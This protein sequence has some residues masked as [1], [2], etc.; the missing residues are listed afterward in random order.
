M[1]D[2]IRRA[3][4]LA[5]WVVLGAAALFMAAGMLTVRYPET[6]ILRLA[7]FGLPAWPA[8]VA[9]IIEI[10]AGA[11]LLHGR[12]RPWAAVVL[13]A[14]STAA[15]TLNF[16]YREPRSALEALGLMVLAVV[17]VLLERRRS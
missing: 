7:A 2:R 11:L 1:S 13:I 12:A 17:V 3:G 5:D 6:A 14:V 15:L 4:P 16:A 10:V 9:G 8:Y